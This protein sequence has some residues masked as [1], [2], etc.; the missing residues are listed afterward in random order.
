[1]VQW[2]TNVG[3]SNRRNTGAGAAAVG[4]FGATVRRP[5]GGAGEWRGRG[6]CEQVQQ[7]NTT[8]QGR[9]REGH[10]KREKVARGRRQGRAAA[11][12]AGQ[13][14]YGRLLFQARG[15]RGDGE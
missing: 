8:E 11:A 3:R 12:V 1:M 2:R 5:G 6:G 4:M 10:G 15:R 9:E 13:R 7:Q 14:R